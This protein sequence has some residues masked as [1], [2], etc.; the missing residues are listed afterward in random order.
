MCAT[1]LIGQCLEIWEG[2]GLIADIR[3]NGYLILRE[4]PETGTSMAFHQSLK[5][6]E[7]E[8]QEMARNG[9]PVFLVGVVR[10]TAE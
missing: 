5:Q 7:D 3:E 10:F 4:S 6:A 2:L 1:V 9:Q 8:A